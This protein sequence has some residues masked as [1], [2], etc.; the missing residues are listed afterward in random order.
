M[1]CPDCN[2]PMRVESESELEG[3]IDRVWVCDYCG[4]GAETCS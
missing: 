4:M 2:K 3:E 1:N